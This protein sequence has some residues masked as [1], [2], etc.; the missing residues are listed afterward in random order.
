MKQ[1]NQET[2]NKTNILTEATQSQKDKFDQSLAQPYS[3]NLTPAAGQNKY[4]DLQPDFM[5]R[6]RDLETFC[7][8]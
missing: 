3:K 6:V 1:T 2:E 4:L 7:S 8:M 5:Q